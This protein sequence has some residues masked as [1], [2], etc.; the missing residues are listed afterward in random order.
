MGIRHPTARL[1][2]AAAATASAGAALPLLTY[3]LYPFCDQEPASTSGRDT[4]SGSYGV[5]RLRSNNGLLQ[6]C[7]LS[8]RL[9]PAPLRLA[10]CTAPSSPPYQLSVAP[11]QVPANSEFEIRVADPVRQ[12]EGVAVSAQQPGSMGSKG[13]ALLSAC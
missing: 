9:P 11:T 8:R 5:S 4:G 2:A 13:Q 12:G 3:P 7:M 6:L 10:A 1:A